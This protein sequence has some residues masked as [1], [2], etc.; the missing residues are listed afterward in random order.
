MNRILIVD[1]D[2][3]FVELVR[4]YLQPEGFSVDAAYDY[5]SG[6]KAAGAGNHE[7]LVLDVMLPGGSGFDLLR[8]LRKSSALPV[9]LLTGR[10]EAVDRIVGLEIGA[11]DYLPKPCDPRELVARI[12]A[13]LRRTQAAG[14]PGNG[15]GDWIRVGAVALSPGLRSVK[16]GDRELDITSIEFNVLEYLIKNRGTVVSRESLAEAALGRKLGLLDRSIDVHV[17]RL[18]RKLADCFGDNEELIKAVRGSGYVYAAM[19]PEEAKKS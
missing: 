18:R 14:S 5:A 11:D 4:E 12:R 13:I 2:R 1:D 10:G 3:D 17:S 15:N 8:N 19:R 7:L 6:L 16:C 9:L